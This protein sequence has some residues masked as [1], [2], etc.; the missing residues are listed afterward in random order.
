MDETQA[1]IT[2]MF[3]LLTESQDLKNIMQTPASEFI[4]GSP[5]LVTGQLAS[6]HHVWAP[7]DAKF[8]Y[9]VHRLGTQES[10]PPIIPGIY[11]LDI[12]DYAP[13]SHRLWSIRNQIASLIDQAEPYTGNGITGLRIFKG[14]ENFIPEDTEG[15]WHYSM[16]FKARYGIGG[17]I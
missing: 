5:Q 15:I 7:P 9:L 14:V 8:P 16:M 3:N 2:R 13:S 1:V 6:L 10:E 17:N 11:Y 4:D 12:W